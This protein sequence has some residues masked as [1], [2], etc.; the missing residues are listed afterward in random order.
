MNARIKRYIEFVQNAEKYCLTL[1]TV[2]SMVKQILPVLHE[3]EDYELCSEIIKVEAEFEKRD[4][5]KRADIIKNAG[6]DKKDLK[7]IL[8]L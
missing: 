8:Y 7:K 6:L 5:L 4:K 3:N 2:K 1:D